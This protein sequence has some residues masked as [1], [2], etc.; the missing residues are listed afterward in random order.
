MKPMPDTAGSVVAHRLIA[1]TRRRV[2]V[3]SPPLQFIFVVL[4]ALAFAA[5]VFQFWPR[6]TAVSVGV[7]SAV[8]VALNT[9]L[10]TVPDVPPPL[11]E[12]FP[13]ATALADAIANSPNLEERDH[14]FLGT[15]CEE[16]E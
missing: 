7:A 3:W 1:K 14:L 15:I 16:F 2:S 13:D 9:R 12:Q 4:C 10:E 8:F 11:E 6:P 5:F